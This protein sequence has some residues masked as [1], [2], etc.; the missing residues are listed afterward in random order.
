MDEN[1]S[2]VPPQPTPPP[3]APISPVPP[4]SHKEFFIIGSLF[5]VLMLLIVSGMFYFQNSSAPVVQQGNKENIL[6]GPLTL[7][8]SNGFSFELPTGWGVSISSTTPAEA[9]TGV[10]ADNAEKINLYNDTNQNIAVLYCGVYI[11]REYFGDEMPTIPYQKK[12][13]VIKDGLQYDISYTEY[14]YPPSSSTTVELEAQ[15]TVWGYDEET[16]PSKWYEPCW[17]DSV[18]AVTLSDK[19][20]MGLRS[21][22]QTWTGGQIVG[23]TTAQN[24]QIPPGADAATFSV[25]GT[26]AVTVNPNLYYTK[27]K[28]HVYFGNNILAGADP[29]TFVLIPNVGNDTDLRSHFAKDKNHVY[30]SYFGTLLA[31]ADPN[32]FVVLNYAYAKDKNN[33]YTL[34]PGVVNDASTVVLSGADPAT[35]QVLSSYFAK[36][37]ASVYGG[38]SKIDNAD[39]QTFIVIAGVIAK[40]KNRVYVGSRPI[41]GA[42]SQTFENVG[43]SSYWKDSLHVYYFDYPDFSTVEGADPTTFAVLNESKPLSCGSNCYYDSQDKNHKYLWGVVVGTTTRQ[44]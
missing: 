15:P 2:A 17:M 32:S 16:D 39:A 27:D 38:G 24:V 4:H 6:H 1:P 31:G 35:F 43:N 12:H 28:D 36:D 41:S 42:D 22:Y 26:P 23:T 25:I 18:L 13:S 8:T 30:D 21:I 37:A 14:D 29:A 20:L 7:Q 3:P 5:T 10:V 44:N 19:D 11:S 34:Q 9:G 40:D 33:V